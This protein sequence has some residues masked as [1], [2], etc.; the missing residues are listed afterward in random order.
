L[1]PEALSRPHFGNC[2]IMLK[3]AAGMTLRRLTAGARC[4]RHRDAAV[5]PRTR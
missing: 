3:I 4:L 5:T 2:Q 1:G